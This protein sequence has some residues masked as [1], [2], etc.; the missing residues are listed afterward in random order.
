MM[1]LKRE[2]GIML[3]SVLILVTILLMI[4]TSMTLVTSQTYNLAGMAEH[5]AKA[6][7]AAEA[8]IEYA[9]YELNKN[10]DWDI[11]TDTYVDLYYSDGETSK[12][13]ASKFENNLKGSTISGTTPPYT[14]E[15]CCEGK[16]GNNKVTLRG[17]FVR[18]D[19]L[20]TS[21]TSEGVMLIDCESNKFLFKGENNGPGRIHSNDDCL[22]MTYDPYYVVDDVDFNKGFASSV[23]ETEYMWYPNLD[24]HF[25]Y[26]EHVNPTDNLDINIGN[27]INRNK[28]TAHHIPG[29]K[30]YMLGYYEYSPGNYLVPHETPDASAPLYTGVSP[31]YWDQ[32]SDNMVYEHP[33]KYGIAVVDEDS[34]E[35]FWENYREL[36]SIGPDLIYLSYHEP[37]HNTNT[38]R[39]LLDYY[40]GV[41]FY[42]LGTP[43]W[44]DLMKELGMSFSYV[45]ESGKIIG[46]L[47]LEDN[48]YTP[49]S[50]GIHE[51]MR[52]DSYGP[53]GGDIGD[54]RLV[55]HYAPKLKLDLNNKVIYAD[56]ELSLATPINTGA[57]VSRDSIYMFEAFE[58]EV[59]MLAGKTAGLCIRDLTPLASWTAPEDLL[60]FSGFIYGKDNVNIVSMEH[61]NRQYNLA[62]N[63]TGAI[64]SNEDLINNNYKFPGLNENY[65]MSDSN[66]AM[67]LNYL[68]DITVIYSDTG[69]TYLKDLRGNEFSV[70]KA[71]TFIDN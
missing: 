35:E 58:C 17:I 37:P 50:L 21:I 5:K 48:I 11:M 42:E 43:E 27:V 18:D 23:G 22:F 46:T 10:P 40:P 52:F 51:T 47:R 39:D 14:A 30:I 71:F 65:G 25:S 16:S 24:P 2:K 36:Q 63:F 9:L 66:L 7:R 59:T 26:R 45:T 70:K 34:I 15:V 55:C 32:T 1:K 68:N 3:I 62:M 41:V 49:G 61:P 44:D 69:N 31:L 20:Y 12:I 57:V 53:G 13:I 8:G 29:D 28:D 6:L 56:N 38:S 64:Y 60:S 4:V 19:H 67:N 54:A 33:Y